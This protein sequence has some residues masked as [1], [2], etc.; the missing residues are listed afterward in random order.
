[1]IE[2]VRGTA[3]ILT[4]I[5]S[6]SELR[7]VS[8][9]SS[10]RAFSS[11]TDTMLASSRSDPALAD[12]KAM[13]AKLQSDGRASGIGAVSHGNAWS[14]YFKDPEENTVEVFCDSPFHVRQPQVRPWDFSMSEE[15]LL[16][17]T[18]EQFGGE[19]EFKPIDEFYAEH[20]RRFGD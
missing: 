1:M 14:V 11:V 15:E 4:L 12:V 2:L 7:N 20:R 19:P 13:A 8:A 18:E 5:V 17:A 10:A 16:Q 6:G 3:V 9:T